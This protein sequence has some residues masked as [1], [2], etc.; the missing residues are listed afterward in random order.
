MKTIGRQLTLDDPAC[1]EI[2]VAGQVEEGWS[3]WVAA[4]IVA[5]TEAGL[6]VSTITG[7]F[8]QAALHGILSRLYS[9]GFPLLSVNLVVGITANNTLGETR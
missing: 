7:T 6:P 9:F 1:Y 4:K 2:A 3:D 8:D 5:T